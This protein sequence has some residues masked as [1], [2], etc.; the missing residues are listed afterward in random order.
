MLI[1]PQVQD[2]A[3]AVL[4]EAGLLRSS[5]GDKNALKEILNSNSLSLEEV[6]QQ[7]SF[8]AHNARDETLQ[9][10][11][12][13]TALKLHGAMNEEAVKIP[14]ITIVIQPSGNPNEGPI[15]SIFIPRE[16]ETNA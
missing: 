14:Q 12:V 2:P 9:M 11:A 15:P 1:K 4:K 5:S 8:T 6:I 13:E 7:L 16:I 10:K 3:S